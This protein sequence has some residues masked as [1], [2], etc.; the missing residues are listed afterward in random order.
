MKQWAEQHDRGDPA[1]LPV[2][3]NFNNVLEMSLCG[4]YNMRLIY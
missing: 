4:I 1:R 2:S 3:K